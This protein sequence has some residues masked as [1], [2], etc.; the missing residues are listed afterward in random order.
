MNSVVEPLRDAGMTCWFSVTGCGCLYV[1]VVLL[2]TRLHG[3]QLVKGYKCRLYS[4]V[5]V[6]TD[7]T[8]WSV[9][10][11]QAASFVDEN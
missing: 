5:I 7:F 8:I 4:V 3:Q 6:G 2:S 11:N 1:Y 9:S 10:C